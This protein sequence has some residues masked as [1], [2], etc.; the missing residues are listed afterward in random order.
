M[1]RI[2][3]SALTLATLGCVATAAQAKKP[4]EPAAPVTVVVQNACA[5]DVAVAFGG[6]ELKVPA[7]GQSTGQDLPGTDDWSYAVMMKAPQEADL[8]LLSLKPGGKYDVK[9]AN[10]RA[11]GADL[12]THDQTERP[13]E[14]S[15]QAAAEVRF[16][17][18]KNVF[19]EYRPGNKGSFKPLSVAMTRYIEHPGGEFE[20]TLR[21]RAA[22]RGP[23]LKMV[24]TAVKLDPGHRYLIEANVAEGD[25]L[26]KREDEGWRTA[27]K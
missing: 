2:V 1:Q 15:P 16:R 5:Q 12:F 8:G 13:A 25:I 21:L 27:E 17:A 20:F 6:S 19:L 3:R 11:G 14:V 23:V 4:T 24:K 9:V 10:C 26:F 18:R 22:K 7:K